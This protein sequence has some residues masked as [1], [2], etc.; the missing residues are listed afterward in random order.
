MPDLRGS[1]GHAERQADAVIQASPPDFLDHP[2]TSPMA[3][4]RYRSRLLAQV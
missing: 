4:I 1:G 2:A 3:A